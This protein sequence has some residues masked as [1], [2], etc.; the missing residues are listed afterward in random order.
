MSTVWK[1]VNLVC[2]WSRYR[3][4]P[5]SSKS[6]I[7]AWKINCPWASTHR[8]YGFNWEHWLSMNLWFRFA[9]Y[10][11]QLQSFSILIDPP[12]INRLLKQPIPENEEHNNFWLC[13]IRATCLAQGFCIEFP[14]SSNNGLNKSATRIK[15]VCFC[16][17]WNGSATE[18]SFFVSLTHSDTVSDASYSS[19]V[20]LP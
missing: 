14:Y 6:L 5:N 3:I 9:V 17:N 19:N 16:F 20:S 1:I 2:V 13:I 18:R 4:V 12:A 10:A 11:A 8:L 7:F 15:Y